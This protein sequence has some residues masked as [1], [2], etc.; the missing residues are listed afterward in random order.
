MGKESLTKPL[1]SPLKFT[2]SCMSCCQTRCRAGPD[3]CHFGCVNTRE[4][5]CAPTAVTMEIRW[6][7]LE[8]QKQ[9]DVSVISWKEIKIA[10]QFLSLADWCSVPP[11]LVCHPPGAE[12]CAFCALPLAGRRLVPPA[13]QLPTAAPQGKTERGDG[14][15]FNDFGLQTTEMSYLWLQEAYHALLAVIHARLQCKTPIYRC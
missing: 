4:E 8:D 14:L 7:P 12:R 1:L 15:A 2:S 10:G 3:G 5:I 13:M 11:G 9:R 6:K